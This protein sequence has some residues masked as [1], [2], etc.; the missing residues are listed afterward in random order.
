MQVSLPARIDHP[1]TYPYDPGLI[2]DVLGYTMV[3]ILVRGDEEYVSSG[4]CNIVNTVGEN[5]G[6]GD[7]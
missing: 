4:S 7:R 3:G 2:L 6:G 5:G 1:S